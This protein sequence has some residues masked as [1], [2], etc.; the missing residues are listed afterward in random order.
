MKR[1]ICV[2][3]GLALIPATVLAEETTGGQEKKPPDGP[4]VEILKKVDAA[5]KAVKAVKYDVA[6]DGVVGAQG[7]TRKIEGTVILSGCVKGTNNPE[8]SLIDIK[9]TPPGAAEA[10][11]ITMGGDGDMFFVIDHQNKK[12]YED[13][14]PA[15]I[16]SFAQYLRFVLMIEFIVDRPFSDEING[17][18]QELK[19]SKEINGVDCHEIH[20][21]YAA[22]A[23]PQA[24][25]YFGKEDF[26]PRG[27]ID[28][29]TTPAGEKI[30]WKKM[31]ANLETDPKLD[32]DV[33]K[34]KLP[35]GYTKTDDFAP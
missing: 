21:V 20:V 11:H 4:A 25:W 16:G 35:E 34:L 10:Q 12:A 33:F 13:L 32:D 19:G 2:L 27:R 3:M 17:K 14:D 26:L 8:K 23:A 28:E 30:V 18:S 15:V 6:F 31:L 1:I 22:D 9:V 7:Q 5:A 24:T 29:L